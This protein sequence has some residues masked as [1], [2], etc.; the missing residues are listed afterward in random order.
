L[1]ANRD[2]LKMIEN[3]KG[4]GPHIYVVVGQLSG[5]QN[6]ISVKQHIRNF[7]D[8]E[9]FFYLIQC[10]VNKIV[11]WYFRQLI[12]GTKSCVVV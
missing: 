9:Q 1:H 5:C 6:N 7:Y 4:G 12:L 2:R 11:F 10:L 8:I 3:R